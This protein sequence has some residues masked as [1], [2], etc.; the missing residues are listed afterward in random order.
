[1][2]EHDNTYL[3]YELELPEHPGAVQRDLKIPPRASFA[4]SIKN[5]EKPSPPGAG[6]KKD[7]EAEYPKEL[8]QEF[9]GR[10]FAAEDERLLDYEG[11]EFILV[12]ARLDPERELA[13]E[14]EGERETPGTADVFRELHMARSRQ[15]TEP[16]FRGQWR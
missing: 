5:P 11:A 15:P 9:R 14:L 16:L 4:L 2:R 8:K 7:Q 6:L 1:M 12:G 13:I 10:R 3:A